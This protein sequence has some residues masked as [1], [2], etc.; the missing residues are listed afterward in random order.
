MRSYVSW[1]AMRVAERAIPWIAAHPAEVTIAAIAFYYERK[2]TMDIIG[3]AA[4]VL[5]RSIV[6]GTG[7]GI[8]QTTA[9]ALARRWPILQTTKQAIQKGATKNP[10]L[11]V[12]AIDIAAAATAISLAKDEDP[13]TEEVQM[14]S[15]SSGIG[16]TGQPSLG[17]FPILGGGSFSF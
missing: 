15:T 7:P 4:G 17:S 14:K 2:L 6:G 1:V 9:T 10:I 12:L 3:G 13:L 11:T 16:G 5:A 8:I